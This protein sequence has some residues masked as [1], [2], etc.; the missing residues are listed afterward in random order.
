M[1]RTQLAPKGNL[2]HMT[3]CRGSAQAEFKDLLQRADMLDLLRKRGTVRQSAWKCQFSE[4]FVCR[5]SDFREYRGGTLDRWHTTI[6]ELCS[7]TQT[8]NGTW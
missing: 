6:L 8:Q 1:R 4:P 2:R 3:G 5:N 7:Q